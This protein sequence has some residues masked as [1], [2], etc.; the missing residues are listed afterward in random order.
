MKYLWRG[1][2]RHEMEG[3]MIKILFTGGTGLIGINIV[4]ILKTKYNIYAPTRNEL[5]LLDTKA[6]EK[7]VTDNC[8]DI[9]IHSANPNPIKNILDQN[10]TMLENS[11]RC[12]MNFYRVR[13][14]C[15]K[16]IFIG[17]GAELDK[18]KSMIQ[19]SE[20]DFDR[21]IP[22]DEYGFAK[23]IMS[24]LALSSEN[25]Y[26]LRLFACYGPGDWESKFITHCIH[27]VLSN[28]D[29]TIHQNCIFDYIQVYDLA[30][31]LS[32][33]IENKPKYHDYNI[34]SGS[35]Y[36]LVEI[37]EK[38]L[39]I[40][41]SNLKINILKDGMNNEY[42]PDISRLLDEIGDYQFIQLDEGIKLQIE[43]ELEKN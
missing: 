5:N 7:Y 14:Y 12:F 38:V 23:Y 1:A 21:S 24:H 40:M 11:L 2:K 13:E 4:P 43:S 18:S 27:S 37:A 39:D 25:V 35:R 41:D 29:I 20:T 30:N 15:K 36:T 33:F 16:L 10:A 42:T 17:S 6:V 3:K 19:I 26:N 22:K 34:A 28:Q 32:Y 31:I 8:F 9:I